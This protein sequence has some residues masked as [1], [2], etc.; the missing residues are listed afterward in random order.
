[1][2]ASPELEREILASM[3]K[4]TSAYSR[5]Q[6]EEALKGLWDDDDVT[7]I[8]SGPDEEYIGKAQIRAGAERDYNST[9]GDMPVSFKRRWVSVGPSE[10]VAWVNGENEINVNVYGN[11]MKIEARFTGIA[12]KRDGA[13]KW[14]TFHYSLPHP[15]QAVG[16][17]YP[18]GNVVPVRS[19]S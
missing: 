11:D 5:G 9:E 17:S 2:K 10:D 14:H 18:T 13:W 12:L 16:Q 6:V 8:E 7:F 1:M 15:E 4:M 19:A 3:D